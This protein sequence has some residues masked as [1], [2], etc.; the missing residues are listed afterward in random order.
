MHSEIFAFEFKLETLQVIQIQTL[1]DLLQLS[2]I[3]L[4]CQIKII[5]GLLIS[6]KAPGISQMFLTKFKASNHTKGVLFCS[7]PGKPA[8]LGGF[9]QMFLSSS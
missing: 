7:F 3:V 5:Q 2:S 1:F 4:K 9:V 8:K 6:R